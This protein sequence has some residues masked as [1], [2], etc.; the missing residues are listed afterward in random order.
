MSISIVADSTCDLPPHIV[1]QFG[2]TILPL[3]INFEKGS[4]LDGVEISREEFYER[5]PNEKKPPSTS[6]PGIELI[7]QTY[8]KLA[9]EGAKEILSLHISKSLSATVDAARTA[10]REIKKIPVTVLDSKQLSL[11]M[12]FLAETAAK[13]A[14]SGKKMNEILA[15]L[16]EQGSRSYVFAALDTLSI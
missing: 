15:A 8:E 6:L 1:K 7:R 14:S 3:Y 9:M 5:L 13:L 11:G 16:D 12:G 4:Y 2:I 10:A